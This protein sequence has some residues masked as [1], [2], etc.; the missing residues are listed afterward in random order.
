VRYV[1][2][3]RI[4]DGF[5]DD[6]TDYLERLPQFADS[7]RLVAG[8]TDGVAWLELQLRHDC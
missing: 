3:E 6:P 4:D 7:E 5:L 8:E 1:K 2:V